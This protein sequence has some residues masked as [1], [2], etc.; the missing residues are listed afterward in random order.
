MEVVALISGGKDSSYNVLHCMNHG[1]K[2]V[3]LANIQPYIDG[4]IDSLMFQSIGHETIEVIAIAIDL[5]LYQ[6][7]T[8]GIAKSTE[9]FYDKTLDDEIEDLYELLV[10]VLTKHP[11]VKGV[12][13]GA[14]LSNYQRLRVENVCNRLGLVSLAYLWRLNQEVLLH[15]MI[16]SGVDAITV[17]IGSLG[18]K[19]D[20]HLGKRL[21]EVEGEFVRLGGECGLN[22]CGE[23]GEYET[24]TLNAPFFKRKVVLDEFQS[25]IASKDPYSPVGYIK[26][27][28]LHLED[29]DCENFPKPRTPPI[30]HKEL[31]EYSRKSELIT[32]QTV[33]LVTAIN[34]EILEFGNN[35]SFG[36]KYFC[37]SLVAYFE[38]ADLA[39]G[40][41]NMMQQIGSILNQNQLN[42]SHIIHTNLFLS[43]MNNYAIINKIYSSYFSI[44]PPSRVCLQIQMLS[45][46]GT[47]CRLEL[48]G[49]RGE[50]TACMHVQSRSFWAPANI[51]PYA[52]C[53][54]AGGWVFVAG[55]IGLISSLM[56]LADVSMQPQLSLQH[57][58]TVLQANNSEVTCFV[59][60]SCYGTNRNILEHC[61][62]VFNTF[63]GAETGKH[64]N[65]IL[66]P[67]LP[68][69]ADCEWQ[70]TS[71]TN[72]AFTDS[73]KHSFQLVDFNFNAFVT[74][75]STKSEG[76]G[77]TIR[78]CQ[79]QQIGE[80]P[81]EIFEKEFSSHL[82]KIKSKFPNLNL[83]M[84]NIRV[85]TVLSHS[86]LEVL[87]SGCI[88]KVWCEQQGRLSDKYGR[89]R[90]MLICYFISTLGYAALTITASYFGFIMARIVSGSFKQGIL[91]SKA[92]LSDITPANSFTEVMGVFSSSVTFGAAIG[93]IIGGHLATYDDT[94]LTSAIV[95]TLTFLFLTI[96]VFFL[97]TPREN[98][99]RTQ[100]KTPNFN[101]I[102]SLLSRYWDI[103][104]LK[105][106]QQLSEV[107]YYSNLMLFLEENYG[108][109][110]SEC[111]YIM[112][113]NSVCAI[114]AAGSTNTILKHFYNNNNIIIATHFTF[115]CAIGYLLILLLDVKVLFLA[116]FLIE[117][118]SMLFRLIHLNLLFSRTSVGDRGVAIGLITSVGSMAKILSPGLAGTNLFSKQVLMIFPYPFSITLV[119][120]IAIV[121]CVRPILI[122]TRSNGIHGTGSQKKVYYRRLMGLSIGKIFS[123]VSS[124]ISILHIPVSYSHTVK[125]TSPV[126]T[127]FLSK[128]ILNESQSVA[129]YLTLVPI[130]CGVLMATISDIVIDMLGVVN[131]LISTGAFTLQNIYSKKAMKD[132]EVHQLQ[133][134]EHITLIALVLFIPI[135]VIVDGQVLFFGAPEFDYE[136]I[137]RIWTLLGLAAISNVGQNIFAFFVISNLSPL[138]YS[139]ANVTKR[140][141][142]I[143]GSLF[144]FK[145]PITMTTIFG[146]CIAISGVF[147]YN[148]MKLNRLV[149]SKPILPLTKDLHSPGL[150]NPITA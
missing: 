80:I 38:S 149:D 18:L 93:V 71:L 69:N 130:V 8:K 136:N 121:V 64:M 63:Y 113:F 41:K 35:T 23:G 96:F 1:H 148:R 49:T 142:I 21:S 98:I 127:V 30:L 50:D 9:L 137:S 73:E 86:N 70:M 29:K 81:F 45:N 103:L 97:P 115:I 90:I 68:K 146:M 36:E 78:I 125:A 15:D 95:I 150:G 112:A 39:K 88:R 46:A 134:L 144:F 5:P 105:L 17:K 132:I 12:S 79:Q 82:F 6:I 56:E 76:V 135:W 14:I 3:A 57:C 84:A 34:T 43:E 75:F 77:L 66:V 32:S 145:D 129:V 24:L 25:V 20:R 119:H 61:Q 122:L 52:Q 138:S 74:G 109:T 89:K 59:I 42:F 133:L 106:V 48:I 118:S 101:N 67:K 116:L 147:L 102:P 55:Q 65:Y 2:I 126:F 107:L 62:V 58:Q 83:N 7:R 99:P 54:T 10:Q 40:V 72:P 111:G 60:G 47:I 51:G 117:S 33:K 104:L 92:Y 4:E 124:H 37:L 87:L 128:L 120:F 19:P 141:V 85:W 100:S 53:Y 22:V 139:V 27:L 44:K 13:S 131:A 28:K 94:F 108:F 143:S 114:I 31:L 110:L 26:I 91:L 140:I 11:E 16:N 123:S